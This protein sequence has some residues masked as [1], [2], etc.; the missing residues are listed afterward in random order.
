MLVD[1]SRCRARRAVKIQHDG[2]SLPSFSALYVHHR[3]AYSHRTGR[4]AKARYVEREGAT[5]F[6]SYHK[7]KTSKP[8]TKAR[9]LPMR[10]TLLGV[11]LSAINAIQEGRSVEPP[12]NQSAIFDG[13]RFP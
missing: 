12:G 6:G 8:M 5:T 4:V 7:T 10:I 13:E 11:G 1:V 2:A 3:G 9:N